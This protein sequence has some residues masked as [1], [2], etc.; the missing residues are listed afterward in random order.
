MNK[1]CNCNFIIKNLLLFSLAILLSGCTTVPYSK[2][3]QLMLSSENTEQK[4]GQIYFKEIKKQGNVS[5]NKIMNSAV[6]RV[7]KNISK[8]AEKNNYKWE[9][10]VIE[11]DDANAFCLPGGKIVVYTGLFKYIKNDAQLATVIGH[12]VGHAIARH[13]GERLSH[14]YLEGAGGIAVDTTLAVFGIPGL[15]GA[16]YGV[17]T[18]LGIDLPYSRTQEYEADHIGLFLMSK[19]GYNPE[20]AITFWKDFAKES[21]Y[22]PVK[23]FF[24]THPMG[25]KRI[26]ELE[27]LLPEAEKVYDSV[28]VKLETGQ[29]ISIAHE[30]DTDSSTNDFH[31]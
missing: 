6:T 24:V 26:E 20:T 8:V 1:H 31:S 9:F 10:A 27:K 30:S 12:E 5:D 18:T 22:G 13:M 25:E 23:E 7:G 19:A 2:R 14:Q 17:A 29:P 3:S 28:P 21:N 15:F 16:A 11:S 4:M